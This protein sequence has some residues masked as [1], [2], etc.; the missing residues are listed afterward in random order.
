MGEAAPVFYQTT[1]KVSDSEEIP[2]VFRYELDRLIISWP[3]IWE[4]WEERRAFSPCLTTEENPEEY[5][6]KRLS[7][8]PLAVT[9]FLGYQHVDKSSMHQGNHIS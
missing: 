1:S 8:G 6:V 9:R 3:W 7:V 5:D 2:E 4:G